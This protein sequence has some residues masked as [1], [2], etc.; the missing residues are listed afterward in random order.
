MIE[1]TVTKANIKQG[2]PDNRHDCPI[3]LALNP[4]RSVTGSYSISVEY[5]TIEIGEL[6][7][8]TPKAVKVFLHR[9]DAG[10]KVKP[11]TFQLV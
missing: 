11:F 2:E 8:K 3:A 4:L 6:S 9:F 7:Y 1:V 5:D 10:K